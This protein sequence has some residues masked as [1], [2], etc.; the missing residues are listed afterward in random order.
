MIDN[1]V[2][3]FVEVGP[4]TVLAGLIKRIDD[5]ARTVRWRTWPLSGRRKKDINNLAK[6]DNLCFNSKT[7]SMLGPRERQVLDGKVAIVTGASGAS[8]GRLR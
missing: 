5:T 3:D 2:T 4:G 1:G 7:G 8:G 6:S